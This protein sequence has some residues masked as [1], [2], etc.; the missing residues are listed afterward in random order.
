MSS[1]IKPGGASYYVI[2]DVS[3]RIVC[4]FKFNFRDEVDRH[5]ADLA[6]SMGSDTC[7]LY[8]AHV[9]ES[10]T[11][12]VL[13]EPPKPVSVM[14]TGQSKPRRLEALRLSLN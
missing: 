7:Y 13:G 14:L 1:R 6:R 2:V 12:T 3:R 11:V 8:P 5:I 4:P 9:V 10:A